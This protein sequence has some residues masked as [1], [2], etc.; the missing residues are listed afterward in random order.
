MLLAP[1]TRRAGA[2]AAVALFLAVF[3]ANINMV[4]MWWD[5]PLA[6]ARIAAHGPA[7]V[8]GADDRPGAQDQAQRS[9][10]GLSSAASS[11]GP[12]S[13]SGVT[14]RPERT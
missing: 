5:K 13:A 14:V 6:D 7:A 8:P 9:A 12:G 2:L 1:R 4:R 3:P 10:S 11:R